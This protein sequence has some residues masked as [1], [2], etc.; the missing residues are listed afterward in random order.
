LAV[1]LAHY[2]DFVEPVTASHWLKA[3]KPC[4]RVRLSEPD[5]T[6]MRPQ[7]SPISTPTIFNFNRALVRRPAASI[8]SGLRAHDLGDPSPEGVQAEHAAYI[9]ALENAGVTVDVLEPLEAYPDSIFV[10]DPALVFTEGAILLRA[11]A[12]SRRGEADA[13]EPELRKRFDLVQSIHRG[14]VDGGDVLA[15]PMGVMIGL[16]E[17]TNLEGAQALTAC[18]SK[19]GR[20]GIIVETPANVLHFKSDCALLDN[21][22]ILSTRRLAASGVFDNF[23]T[24]I[25]P[26]GE[27]A[28]ANALRVNNVVFLNASAPKTADLLETAGLN[29]VRLESSEINK[30]DAGLSCMSLRWHGRHHAA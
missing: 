4:E 22:R 14:T 7:S 28:A 23:K 11:G 29:I 19:I 8:V 2:I 18:L 1:F 16:S 12:A 17:R 13:L 25:V 10:E 26:E 30:I 21:D 3:R 27:D 15:T 20:K 5:P 6:N 24:L 9:K